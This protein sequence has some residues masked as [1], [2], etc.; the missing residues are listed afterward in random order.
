MPA[1]F[2]A[3]HPVVCRLIRWLMAPNPA[4]R[5]T[6]VEVQRSELLPPQASWGKLG[7]GQAGSR[8]VSAW[9]GG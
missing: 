2:E 6:A 7:E 3:R 4:E 1:K 5:P 8:F 9:L